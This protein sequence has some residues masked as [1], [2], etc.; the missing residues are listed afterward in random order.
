MTKHKKI[1]DSSNLGVRRNPKFNV[2][3]NFRSLQKQSKMDDSVDSENRAESEQKPEENDYQI[4]HWDEIDLLSEISKTCK[5]CEQKAKFYKYVINKKGQLSQ[6]YC[7]GRHKKKFIIPEIVTK[8][9]KSENKC[10]HEGKKKCDKRALQ[11]IGKHYYCT[12][13]QKAISKK[14][15]KV[16]P[17]K[18]ITSKGYPTA[19][20][21]LNLIKKLDEMD[22]L[23]E[24]D[25]IVIENQP[26]F[27]GPKMKT[28]AITLFNYFL[29]RDI[30][31]QREGSK[32][33]NIVFFS[34]SNK[35]YVDKKNHIKVLSK[36][37]VRQ[38]KYKLTKDLSTK[39]CKRLL[40]QHPKEMKILESHK[41]QDDMSDCYL[42]AIYYDKFLRKN[43]ENLFFPDEKIDEKKE[44]TICSWDVG[45]RHLAYCVVKKIIF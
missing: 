35:I 31:D 1:G 11:K 20:L 32:V 36:E 43:K 12:V 40:H 25:E 45:T 8:I 27:K 3:H 39:Y 15:S 22:F 24:C 38:H 34:P 37:L 4:C 16:Y 42:Q 26:T 30:V 2:S 29:T 23:K 5:L 6:Q 44:R 9:K 14:I 33:K 41:K 17:L 13:H 10:E 7:C 28:M 19:L 18:K 21:T